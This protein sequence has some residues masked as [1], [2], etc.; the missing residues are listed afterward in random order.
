MKVIV[1]L[2]SGIW[3]LSLL[4][5]EKEKVTLHPGPVN[6]CIVGISNS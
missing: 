6:G 2:K 4:V 3:W 1:K 5:C